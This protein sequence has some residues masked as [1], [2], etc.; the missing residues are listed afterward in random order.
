MNTP[1]LVIGGA[2]SGVGKTTV[3]TGRRLLNRAA[4]EKTLILAFHFPFLG[5][6]C[7]VQKRDA[8]QWQPIETVQ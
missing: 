7:I 4:T 2:S 6:G 1:R 3:T 5:L 8:W